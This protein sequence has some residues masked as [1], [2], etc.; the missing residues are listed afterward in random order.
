MST[1]MKIQRQAD[2]ILIIGKLI[3][4]S[5]DHGREFDS[6][7]KRILQRIEFYEKKTN[8]PFSTKT[9]LNVIA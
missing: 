6:L 2:L 9:N 7:T 4:M 5:N 1:F 8:N 3:I